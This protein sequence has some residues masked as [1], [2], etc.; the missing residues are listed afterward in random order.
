[1]TVAR[2]VDELG[3]VGFSDIRN[4][5]TWRPEVV[6]EPLEEEGTSPPRCCRAA[7]W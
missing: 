4:V 1:V 7:S 2:V 5:V 3:K 6:A